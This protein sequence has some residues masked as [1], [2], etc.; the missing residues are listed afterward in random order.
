MNGM[1]Q[2]KLNLEP[3]RLG[4][5]ALFLMVVWVALSC[6]GQ[7]HKSDEKPPPLPMRV[8]P[9]E[10]ADPQP[11][12]DS[13]PVL[14]RGARILTAAG[15]I[16]E[17]G[18][19]LM[20][21]GRLQAVGD[22]PG[23]APDA[24]E[25][26][27]GTGKVVTPG[28]IDIHSHLGLWSLP[29]T[30]AN[31]DIN[32]TTDPVT[33]DIWAE[34]GFWPQDPGIWR[35]MTSGVTTVQTLP[36]S[37]NLFGGRT[38][39]FKLKPAV[40]ARAMRF[41]GA[42]QGLKMAC[43][44][45]PKGIYGKKRR[46]ATR[47]GSVAVYRSMFQQALAYRDK[48]KKYERDKAFWQKRVARAEGDQAKLAGIGDPP[49]L[50]TRDFG[51]ETLVKALDG[52]ILFNVHC[53]R[54][55]EMAVFLDIAEAFGFKAGSFHHATNA[56]K[57]RERLAK[58]GV[59]AVVWADWFG[60]KM[61]LFDFV[62]QNAALLEQAG[63]NVAFHSDSHRVIR[64]LNHEVAKSVAAGARIGV[65]GIDEDAALGWLT[66][67][68]AR[69]LEIDD[70]VG[71]LEVGKM[72]DVVVWDMNPFSVYAHPEMVFIDGKKYFD[73]ASQAVEID[74]FEVGIRNMDLAD[75]RQFASASD[76][77]A[78]SNLPLANPLAN[79]ATS[80]QPKGTASFAITQVWVEAGNGSTLE[81]ATVVVRDGR[82]ESVESERAEPADIPVIDGAGKV[83]TPGLIW[84]R[85]TLGLVEVS[86]EQRTSDHRYDGRAVS[87]GF[88]VADAFNP[89]TYRIPIVRE[90]GITTAIA[91][92]TGQL[93]YGTGFMFDLVRG[94]DRGFEEGAR[95]KPVPQI[96]MFGGISGRAKE[97]QGK[98]RGGVW[99]RFR[100]IFDDV[101]WYKK[102]RQAYERGQSRELSLKPVHLQALIPVFFGNLPLVLDVH[103]ASDIRA[104]LSF[105][106]E[107]A[108][109]G[110]ALNLIISGGSEAWL[111]ADE[112]ARDRIPVMVT[113]SA[114][115]PSSFDMLRARDD[116]PALLN[117]KGVK[118]IING[119]NQSLRQEGG[120]AVSYGLDRASAIKAMTLTPAELFEQG[121]E[122]GSV[123]PGKR[124]NLVLWSGDPLENITLAERLW[125][126]GKEI[127]LDNRHQQLAKRYLDRGR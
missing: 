74:D 21:A 99:L 16:F 95:P 103:R 98:T 20:A 124:A 57:L 113:P 36:G 72:A 44:E 3:R 33:A 30:Q 37:A 8:A 70:Q 110:G 27:D 121:R 47:M 7:D 63:V 1:H 19:V 111:V 100:E 42:K 2:V 9:E 28:L 60:F 91:A 32:E 90:Q 48:L 114:Q 108:S 102:N 127:D 5:G 10:L 101:K 81:N 89:D 75:G 54:E 92:P 117:S 6:A 97:S 26:I 105:R 66:I 50:P 15:Q 55:D 45:N 35:A 4:Y 85:S 11:E 82:I 40:S 56:Y 31:E 39:V 14:I 87:P 88:R 46:P 119:S 64:H 126:D 79:P 13:K 84:A 112:L 78:V 125:I 76:K 83:V 17:S 53:Y 80:T 49:E 41:P 67:N 29:A 73:R 34:H 65:T 61:E 122:I 59:T 43:G 58:Q 25:I 24:A 123:E 106:K 68:P 93:I 71:S 104:A 12:I 115:M 38:F 51:L 52:E 23:V 107:V 77:P 94:N 120:I 96:A 86:A 109:Q 22:G 118:L 18:H 116:L 69:A 62:P